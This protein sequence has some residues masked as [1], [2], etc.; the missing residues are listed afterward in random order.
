ML[1]KAHFLSTE[2]RQVNIFWATNNYADW[3][4]GYQYADPITI[5]AVTGGNGGVIRSRAV[6]SR[7][8]QQRCNREMAEVFTPSWLCNKQNNLIDN[9]RFGRE[10]V[11]NT[12]IDNADGSHSWNP[13]GCS[14]RIR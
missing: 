11:F 10:N 9:A 7:E 2:E 4:A 1:L 5:E 13:P 6:K 8:M 12:E 14:V 3:G